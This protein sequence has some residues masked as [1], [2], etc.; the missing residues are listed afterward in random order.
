MISVIDPDGFADRAGGSFETAAQAATWAEEHLVSPL[1]LMAVSTKENPRRHVF[2]PS[3]EA[4]SQAE[5]DRKVTEGQKR[6]LHVM[7]EGGRTGARYGQEPANETAETSEARQSRWE[8]RERPW[9]ARTQSLA[10]HEASRLPPSVRGKEPGLLADSP[11]LRVARAIQ[12][13]R[14]SAEGGQLGLLVPDRPWPLIEAGMPEKE[15]RILTSRAPRAFYPD[16]SGAA[17]LRLVT[18][19]ASLLP[20]IAEEVGGLP[21]VR[22]REITVPGS[23]RR[24]LGRLVEISIATPEGQSEVF[25]T[26]EDI[27]ERI[28]V[29]RQQIEQ[30]RPYR[31]EEDGQRFISELFSQLQQ[32]AEA[33]GARWNASAVTI[34]LWFAGLD[35]PFEVVLSGAEHS[36]LAPDGVAPARVK[37]KNL[38]NVN[39]V[40][41]PRLLVRLARR[42][43]RKGRRLT[44][45]TNPVTNPAGQLEA[46]VLSEQEAGRL[47][48]VPGK[49]GRVYWYSSRRKQ[50]TE[51]TESRAKSWLAIAETGR[52][53]RGLLQQQA[54]RAYTERE[55]TTS[56]NLRENPMSYEDDYWFEQYRQGP[57]GA[58]RS[59]PAARRNPWYEGDLY[60]PDTTQTRSSLVPA[61]YDDYQDLTARRS[62]LVPGPYARPN[63]AGKPRT[64]K[65]LKAELRAMG[66]PDS[67]MAKMS[68]RQLEEMLGQPVLPKSAAFKKARKAARKKKGKRSASRAAPGAQIHVAK[69]GQPY[70]ILPDGRARFI[71][72]AEAH[73]MGVPA[74]KMNPRKRRSSPRTRKVDPISY[75]RG[76]FSSTQHGGWQPVNRRNPGKT[77]AQRQA[78]QAMR[79][80]HSGRASSLKQAWK[81]VKGKA[82]AN[83][84]KRRSKKRR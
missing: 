69:N 65:A 25:A 79:L 41:L 11:E 59:V 14:E 28:N 6:S 64:R 70:I 40:D 5:Y 18:P 67:A 22:A 68:V 13:Y 77:H 51:T 37:Y 55:L 46:F 19:R 15:A 83:G 9:G 53:S 4:D 12:R 23:E 8:R 78:A 84:R 81:M 54:Q 47:V 7:V 72:K 34:E 24:G 44:A 29:Y 42:K 35:E 61:P 73:A 52:A 62:A 32:A 75:N 71:S 20:R 2:T 27:T 50:L 30:T 39:L 38:Q 3:Y 43:N 58:R 10:S 21:F 74:A 17:A 80:Y 33:L 48:P 31:H 60:L 56:P 45:R 1:E 76:Q 36:K 49:P 82:K 16:L 57:Y 26:D 63:M 66:V